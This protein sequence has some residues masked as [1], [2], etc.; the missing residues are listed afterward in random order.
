DGRGGVAVGNKPRQRPL[1]AAGL[2]DLAAERDARRIVAH[3][4]IRQLVE[5]RIEDRRPHG[6]PGKGARLRKGE[7]QK[8]GGDLPP[9]YRTTHVRRTR[10]L[11]FLVE[12][13]VEGALAGGEVEPLDELGCLAG[14]VLAVHAAVFP[15]DRQG[16]LVVDLVEG[17]DD[18][19]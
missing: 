16:P 6:S 2:E 12:R 9:V 4:R 7:A 13:R 8:P 5:F 3:R 11:L 1:V 17:A 18:L 10:L 19:L 14:A 15:L